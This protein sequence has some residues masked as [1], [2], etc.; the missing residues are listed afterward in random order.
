VEK[1][2]ID[3]RRF[4][5]S[6]WDL[7]GVLSLGTAYSSVVSSAPLIPTASLKNIGPLG[8]PNPIGLR[9]PQG[10]VGREVAR[11][12][13]RVRRADG[14]KLDYKWH[15]FPDGG[16]CFKTE[17]GGWIYTSNSEVQLPG[18]GGAGAIRFN[19][20]GDVVDAY[21]I[22]QGTSWNCAGGPTPWGTWLS[23][24][25]V[26][27]GYVYECDVTGK[28]PAQKLPALGR[29][30]HEAVAVDDERQQLYLTEDRDDGRFYRF[31][32]AGRLSDGR[33]DLSQGLLEAARVE[34]NRVSWVQIPNPTPELFQ[35]PTR[36][37]VPS[38]TPF[39]GGEG[40]WYH[41]GVV[42][43]TTKGDNRVWMYDVNENLISIKYDY[44][45][46]E[47]PQLKGVD[48][49]T[50]TP[51]GHV[52]V[53]EDGGNMQIVILG[54][55]GDIY[56]LVQVVDQDHSEITGPALSPNGQRLY[57][58]SQRGHHLGLTYEMTGRFY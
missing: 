23:C 56:P 32:A 21:S 38:S 46:A 12:G 48:N 28:N 20:N 41:E 27:S 19:G 31:T 26:E 34:G 5:R 52:L 35:T 16:A 13:H 47:D 6:A 36:H 18:G 45:T 15:T 8:D 51:D 2:A 33:L 3:R 58:S 37:Q 9:L 57:F 49:I 4:V 22:L 40:I 14:K 17:D 53:A 44:Q 29:F 7:C 25:E 43:F 54:P 42:Y 30:V 11:S 24:E 1:K 39:R 55:Y 50:V 10:F